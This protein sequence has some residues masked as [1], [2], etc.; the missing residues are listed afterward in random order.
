MEK[1]HFLPKVRNKARMSPL[2][3]S[4]Q[5]CTGCLIARKR[6][7]GTPIRREEIKLFANDMI[8]YT[9]NPKEPIKCY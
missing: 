7:K 8:V 2:T 5:Y 9:E 1:D 6:V 3:T 4:I